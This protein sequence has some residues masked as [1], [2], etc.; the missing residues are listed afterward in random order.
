[1]DS[2][3][4]KYW[5]NKEQARRA[6]YAAFGLNV[7]GTG[8]IYLIKSTSD[9]DYNEWLRMMPSG[10]VMTTMT[11]AIAACTSG[12][13]DIIVQGM[14]TLTEA[15]ALNKDDVRIVGLGHSPIATVIDGDGSV[16]FTVTG[17]DCKFENI[18]VVTAGAAIACV[19]GTALIGAPVFENCF[20]ENLTLT[21]VACI[22]IAGATSSGL[23]VTDSAF[24]G[25][26]TNADA[27]NYAGVAGVCYNNTAEGLNQTEGTCFGVNGQFN[28]EAGS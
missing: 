2:Y 25:G 15:V 14:G 11:K 22:N 26:N 27:V 20:F 5:S 18:K 13:G 3:L 28:N 24:Y 19:Y 4:G 10:N 12:K 6:L 16:G 23:K 8:D 21:S 7:V 17:V 9:A 1:M